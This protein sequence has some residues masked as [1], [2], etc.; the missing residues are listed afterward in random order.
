METCENC[1]WW[2]IPDLSDMKECMLA[3]L[4]LSSPEPR[5]VKVIVSKYPEI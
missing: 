2:N 1:F 4:R 5:M 3:S